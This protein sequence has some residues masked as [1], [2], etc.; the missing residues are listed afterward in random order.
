MLYEIKFFLSLLLTLIIEIPI[1][2]LIAR[3]FKIQKSVAEIVFISLTASLLTLPY[4]WFVFP[5]LFGLESYVYIGEI[6]VLLIESIIYWRLLETKFL[7]AIII[8]F[9]ANF[10]SFVIGLIVGR[11][12][13]I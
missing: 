5:W 4:L 3:N 13:L 11:I 1:V 6:I 8:S 9:F 2:L 10:S 7:R 12:G